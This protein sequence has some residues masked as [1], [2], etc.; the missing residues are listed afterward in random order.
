MVR[1]IPSMSSYEM[2]Y[3]L[4][5]GTEKGLE[6]AISRRVMPLTKSYL[7][8]RDV[9]NASKFSTIQSINTYGEWGTLSKRSFTCP[10]GS[11]TIDRATFYNRNYIIPGGRVIG[12]GQLQ[13]L[14]KK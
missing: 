9:G 4:G 11:Y 12:T 6:I 14:Q 1:P 5:F 3:T 13:Y 10:N 7:E 8:V 2:G